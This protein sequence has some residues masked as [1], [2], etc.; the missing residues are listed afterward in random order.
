MAV[1]TT[2][3]RS[4][5]L[6]TLVAWGFA[7]IFV[8]APVGSAEGETAG[9][10]RMVE[11]LIEV[12]RQTSE[13][14]PWLNTGRLEELR[15]LNRSQGPPQEPS[16]RFDFTSELGLEEFR[17]GSIDAAI[18]HL[19]TALAVLEMTSDPGAVPVRS[20]IRYHLGLAHLRRA[21]RDN[22][23]DRHS[24]KS[25][26]FP[27]R[28][29]GVH[30]LKDDARQA[31]E[32]FRKVLDVTPARTVEH[33]AARWLLNIA[34]M[35]LGDWPEALD[36]D[37]RI[38]PQHF[39]SEGELPEFDDIAHE[40]GLATFDLAGGAVV[41]DFDGD[42]RLDL[43]TSTWEPS[44][45][46]HFFSQ[47]DDGTF[48]ER[49]QAAGLSGITGGLNLLQADYDGDGDLD[50][51]V[52]RGAWL[53]DSGY[54]PNSLLANDGSGRF[55]DVTFEAGLGEVHYPTQTASWADY[56][57]D[58]DLDLYI[59]NE[60]YPGQPVPSQLFRNRGDGRFEDVAAEAGV[61]N[62]LYAKAVTWGDY[63]RDRLPDLYVSNFHGPN[64]LF[65]NLGDGRFEDVAPALGVTAPDESFPAWFWD[66][67]NDGNLD[68]YVT[69]YP[70]ADGPARL[71]LVVARYL[72]LATSAQLPRLYRGDGKGGFQDVAPQTGLAEVSMPMGANFGDLDNDGFLDFYLGTGYPNYDGLM[73]N[74]LYRNR[75]G[76]TFD[77]VTSIS[78]LGHLQKGH[79]VVFAD[80]DSDG[81]QDVF[82]Q[83][84][85]F[86]PDDAYSNAL[87]E[88]PGFGNHW[89]R[90]ELTGTVSN[91]FGVGARIRA[92][93]VE[94]GTERSVYA[95]VGSGATFGANPL[96][97]HLGLGRATRVERLEVYWPTSD[98]LQTMEDVAVD[99]TVEIVEQPRL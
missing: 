69:S 27:I 80:V 71:F 51:L 88:N 5:G 81:D 52:L 12:A 53:R 44:G 77:D 73:P 83:L 11:A 93:I 64:R 34:H 66:Y 76:V 65:R 56:D 89:L 49:S 46:M 95:T 28:P 33:L 60:S 10:R 9:H 48:E 82:E 72:G 17:L 7:S 30:Q 8:S 29:E 92:V 32:H 91:H 19:D 6:G 35:T 59:G 3:R 50:V 58:G 87:F 1:T 74:V 26:I 36:T 68:L 2:A 45:P 22:C 75:G 20:R 79:A 31:A 85:G 97:Q 14:N 43:M 16:A 18:E 37:D 70:D 21:E 84:G 86:F 62:M 4:I 63:D 55:V 99:Q 39:A 78:G 61:E 96:T 40:V 98:T 23:V 54:H 42:G 94:D 13:N 47:R 41:D 38:D 24:A 15:L 67:D 90:V 25:C 57:N